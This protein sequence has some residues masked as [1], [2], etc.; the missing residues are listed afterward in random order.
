MVDTFILVSVFFF[1]VLAFF[2]IAIVKQLHYTYILTSLHPVSHSIITSRYIRSAVV[3]LGLP[4]HAFS[5]LN[6]L[7]LSTTS[8]SDSILAKDITL[9]RSKAWIRFV[10]WSR[11]VYFT[12]WFDNVGEFRCSMAEITI[13]Y[14]H[15]LTLSTILCQVNA[16]YLY[17][18]LWSE[19]RQTGYSMGVTITVCAN[20]FG[21]EN[22]ASEW[23][24]LERTTRRKHPEEVPK[25]FKVGFVSILYFIKFAG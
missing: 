9:D 14:D 5:L 2:T 10:H 15:V 1:S 23:E 21:E 11:H 3:L 8:I 17:H 7:R 4:A 24:T 12:S 22:G 19:T 13:H 25:A 16:G 6:I 20:R 18:H